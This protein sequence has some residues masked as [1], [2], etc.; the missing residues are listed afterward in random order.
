FDGI[1][2]A[3]ANVEKNL[4]SARLVFESYLQ[5]AFER[6]GNHSSKLPLSTLCEI[7]HGFAFDG[8]E[9]GSDVAEGLPVVITPVN[10]TEDGKLL[11]NER[12]TKRFI[13]DPPSTFRFDGGDLV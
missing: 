11:F 2:T 12:I 6:H 13:G 5:F 7:K 9:F 1:A 8:A 4:Q 3:K 10:F